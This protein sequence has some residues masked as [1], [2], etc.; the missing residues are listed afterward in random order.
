VTLVGV[1]GIG[2]SR[3]VLELFRTVDADLELITW[4]QGRSLPYGEGMAFWGLAEMVKGQAGILETDSAEEAAAKL[5]ATTQDLIEEPGESRWVETHLQPLVGIAG[6]ADLGDKGQ[7]EAFA[8]WRRFLEALAERGPLVLVF[9]D[10]HWA[11]DGLL[12]FVDYLVDWAVEV[13]L[14]VVCTARPELVAR[15]PGWGGGKANALI[16]SLSALTDEE[17]ARLVH[18]LLERAVLPAELQAKL[19]E[20]A[21]GNPLYAEEFAR[22]V[23]ERGSSDDEELRLPESLQGL[24]A[25][26]LDGLSPV[27]KALVQDAAVIGKVFWGSALAALDGRERWTLEEALHVLE[28]KQ[29]V[30]RERRSSVGGETQ[31]AF[32][33]L[34]IRDV[35]YGQIPRAQ[36]GEKHRLAAEWIQSLTP[37]RTE[38]RAEMLA[39]HYLAALEL[40]GSAGVDTTSLAAPARDAFREA[41]DRALGLNAFS[42]AE[43]YYGAA[44]DLVTKGD[45]EWPSLRFKLSQASAPF[46]VL[47][48]EPLA[49]VVAEFLA[50]GNLEDAAEVEAFIGAS[51]RNRGHRDV[52]DEHLDRAFALVAD[53][54]L[55]PAKVRVLTELARSR[56]LAGDSEGAVRAGQE[57]L[58]MA[59]QLSL[60]DVRAVLLNVVGTSRV[61][62][63]DE[64]GLADLERSLAIG[65]ELNHASHLHRTY[66]NLMESYRVI[67]RLEK[68]AEVLAAERR[69]DERF[70]LQEQLR[71]VLGEEAVNRYLRGDW[72]T[73]LACVEEFM[74]QVEAG[75]PHYQEPGLRWVRTSIA[76]AR[77]DLAVADEDSARSVEIARE[78][79]DLQVLAP[80]LAQ[81][82]V[83]LIA[84]G[85]SAEA[86]DVVDELLALPLH[87]ASLIDLA[88]ALTDLGRGG[89]FE[90]RAADAH[91][92]PW[93]A[94]AIAI[95]A[96]RFEAAAD[97]LAEMGDVADEAYARLRSGHHDQVQRALAF[98]RSVGATR[99]IQEGEAL[100]AATA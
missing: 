44:L 71:W 41:G 92:T 68:S 52:A 88:W 34:V 83:A 63:G 40:F 98:H 5:R 69:S 84:L 43:R 96:G 66:H 45:P 89:D 59:E 14:L 80:V 19:L 42:A 31:Y 4:R 26:R 38:D 75:S 37:D 1:P 65:L 30:R 99:Y 54:P 95:A 3:L 91:S 20:R 17:T 86:S 18:A 85:R 61:Q 77:A 27:E 15:R 47:E 24:V 21:G 7:A 39:H 87:Y 58:P 93:G 25:A 16:I 100:L 67:G 79:K 2:K 81:R 12:D 51:A 9:E 94:V 8:A 46:R 76:L 97:V 73:A 48:L 50:L 35:A 90:Q 23:E 29:F 55:S 11:D 72:E 10:L 49:E 64:S 78:Q 53:A 22:T 13:P 6:E 57:V 36:R 28:R 74:A 33:H 56:M 32:L 62:I 60:D 70:G 82:A